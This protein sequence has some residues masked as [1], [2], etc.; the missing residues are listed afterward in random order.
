MNDIDRLRRE[1]SLPDL[2]SDY[3]VA[4]QKNGQEF[5]GCCPFH[6]EN[7]PSFTIFPGKDAVWRFHCFGCSEQGDVLDFVQK[8]KG[9]ELREAISILGGGSDRPNVAPKRIEARD[10]YAGITLLEPVSRIE[11]GR[12]VRVYNPKRDTWGDLRPSMVFPY[13]R[14]GRPLGYVLRRDLPGG[15]KETP[16]VCWVRLRDGSEAWSRYPLPKP[17][18]LYIGGGASALRDGQVIVVEGEKAADAMARAT[19]RQTVSW[20]GGTFGIRHADWS[21]IAGRSVVIWPDADKP[22]V[23]TGDDIAAL[24]AGIGCTVKV[25][26]F[27]VA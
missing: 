27:E 23:Q 11:V 15:D 9:V 6:Q 4:L 19:G 8:I 18:P 7:T 3:G 14:A 25:M 13:F 21:L 12:A 26:R 10:P 2:A 24:L 20:A 17:R 16:M 22:G 5:E 1:V